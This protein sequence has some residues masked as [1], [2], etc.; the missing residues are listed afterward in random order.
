LSG[1]IP[2]TLLYFVGSIP[3][4]FCSITALTALNISAQAAGALKC[5]PLCLTT[6]TVTSGGAAASCPVNMEKGICGI[7]AA[8]NIAS[9]SNYSK[10]SCNNAGYISSAVCV[11]GSAQWPGVGC[12]GTDV[13][14]LTLDALGLSGSLPSS[15]GLLTAL[16][17]IS[18][19]SNSLHGE[20]VH[21]CAA[22]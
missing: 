17:R 4:S 14:D 5:Y 2:T 6:A 16:T 3:N 11:S 7:V 13:V 19:H 9:L 10:W 22:L 21:T 18:L 20:S 12:S 8:T 15:L 1:P